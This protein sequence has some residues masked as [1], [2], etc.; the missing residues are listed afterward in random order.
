MNQK[1][2]R[3]IQIARYRT[4]GKVHP[5]TGHEISPPPGFEPQT[6]KPVKSFYTVWAIPAYLFGMIISISN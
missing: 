6:G 5:V 4:K 3:L 2:Y 1:N